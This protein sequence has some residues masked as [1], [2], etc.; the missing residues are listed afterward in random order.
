MPIEGISEWIGTGLFNKD[1]RPRLSVVLA[2]IVVVLLWAIAI[3]G[4]SIHDNN[5]HLPAP[6][7]GLLDHYGFQASFI[8]APMVLMTCY[9]ALSYLLRLLRNIDQVLAPDANQKIVRAIIEP[10][11]KS[12]FLRGKWRN[13][14]W[15]LMI[16]GGA[17]SVWIFKKLDAPTAYWG[18]DVFNAMYYR[19]SFIVANLYL[20]VV[21]TIICPI[22][23]FYALHITASVEIIVAQLKRR[24]LFRLNFLDIDRCGGMSKFG[25]L[26]LL[27][28][29]IYVWPFGAFYALHITHRYNYSSLIGGAITVSI[30]LIAQST[31][32][33]YWVSQTIKSEQESFVDSL[34]QRIGKGMEG[35]RKNFAAAVAAMQYRDKVLSVSLYPY[36]RG[37]SA[38]V[39][40]LRLAPTV[41]AVLKFFS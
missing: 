33:I 17:V 26:N 20:F 12:M 21:W 41:L 27:I 31:Y 4:A 23:F 22:V 9:L 39:N 8:A 1:L 25:T 6:G 18:N 38:A 19:Y 24:N 3:I 14:L 2:T 16:V 30:A 13:G 29:L 34:N 35:T 37:V 36:S 15:L 32:G 28:M 7:R 5:L 11:I 40:I 10:H